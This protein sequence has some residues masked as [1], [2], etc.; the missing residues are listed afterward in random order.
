MS[1]RSTPK[2]RSMSK[3]SVLDSAEVGENNRA[4]SKASM[5]DRWGRLRRA[6]LEKKT[7]T[8]A[9]A[10]PIDKHTAMN[11]LD[12]TQLKSLSK[13]L[14]EELINTSKAYAFPNK[15]LVSRQGDLATECYVILHGKVAVL[16]TT[17]SKPGSAAGD[18]SEDEAPRD[19]Q[20]EEK[21][22][23]EKDSPKT[24]SLKIEK[25][26]KIDADLAARQ[27]SYGR[28]VSQLG[29]GNMLGHHTFMEEAVSVRMGTT[30]CIRY[31][32]VLVIQKEDFKRLVMDFWVRA[33][34]RKATILTVHFPLELRDGKMIQRMLM[35]IRSEYFY[36]GEIA[37]PRTALSLMV[38]GQVDMVANPRLANLGGSKKRIH[39]SP[40]DGSLSS[41]TR[42]AAFMAKNGSSSSLN[43][44]PAVNTR[45][46]ATI[47]HI[48]SLQPGSWM[49]VENLVGS[50]TT[51]KAAQLRSS[52]S[53]LPLKS[54]K[55]AEMFSSAGS[56]MDNAKSGANKEK[57]EK[58]KNRARSQLGSLPIDRVNPWTYWVRSSEPVETFLVDIKIAEQVQPYF[59]SKMWNFLKTTHEFHMNRALE[60]TKPEY[61]DN[62]WRTMK[63]P[64]LSLGRLKNSPFL[65]GKSD[66]VNKSIDYAYYT[67]VYPSYVPSPGKMTEEG[68]WYNSFPPE[69]DTMRWINMGK[70]CSKSVRETIE[71]NRIGKRAPST[72]KTHPILQQIEVCFQNRSAK[73]FS[74]YLDGIRLGVHANF[75][76]K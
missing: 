36:S 24:K 58:N 59:Q 19:Q 30:V 74:P 38:K 64:E 14:K 62:M 35:A 21:I 17:A 75:K 48:T 10:I 50:P 66:A 8:K 76:L 54:K 11:V 40:S 26:E 34:T 72:G 43:V 45:R 3:M 53:T 20:D 6:I 60:V 4:S 9:F 52:S 73:M 51:H 28:E 37:L 63:A 56:S 49:G 27:K 32:E 15:H 44:I 29:E 67:T 18:E 7:F 47:K 46:S 61:P 25:V 65:R 22:N 69:A 13:E 1:Q 41:F 2:G 39:S 68:A 57:E 12:K 5:L 16:R 70:M 33:E 71:I 55:T 42:C 23:V 31:C